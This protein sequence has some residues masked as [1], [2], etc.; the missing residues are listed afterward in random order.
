MKPPVPSK[1]VRRRELQPLGGGSH[2]CRDAADYGI[3][4]GWPLRYSRV[5]RTLALFPPMSSPNQDQQELNEREQTI[6]RVLIREYVRTG[7]P[8]GSRRMAKLDPNRMSPAT[9]RNVVS[10]LEEKGFVQ[11][12]HTS[13]GRVPTS[14]GYR[15]YVD[16][17]AEYDVLSRRDLKKIKDSLEEATA[18]EELMAKTS[19][20]LSLFSSNL[21]FVLAPPL[22]GT[23][24]KRIEFVRISPQRI[25]V[26]LVSQTGQV[27]NRMVQIDEDLSQSDLDQ[28][29]RYLVTH[30]SGKT[31]NEMRDELIGLM[32][33]EKALYDRMLRNVVLVSTAGLMAQGDDA[34]PEAEVYLGGTEEIIRQPEMADV[35][36]MMFL[37]QT[38]EEKSRAV[39]IITE[40]LATDG[41]AVRIG[42]ENVS[43]GLRDWTVISSPYLC[44]H[45]MV[46]GLGI[47]GPTRMEYERAISL[48]DYVAKV[49]GRL[50]TPQ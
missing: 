50:I 44:N 15:F 4:L 28:V 49:F 3:N 38:F 2:N 43:P 13:A 36:R 30:F 47:I 6:L 20:I 24:I 8:V 42:L 27:Q 39:R 7:K 33:E 26:I 14:Q 34:D 22:T 19:R 29:G 31:L 18:P 37:F 9:I 16:S 17:M 25:L 12:P 41:T 45:Q 10:D 48:V 35:D 11:Q 1:N 5:S 40:C 21:G 23:L 46:G 32:S